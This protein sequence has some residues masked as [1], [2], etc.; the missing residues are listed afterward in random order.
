MRQVS[1]A[2]NALSKTTTSTQI[3]FIEAGTYNEQVYIPAL[4][5]ELIIYGQTSKSVGRFSMSNFH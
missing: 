3:I 2:V 1:A 4:A 5:G